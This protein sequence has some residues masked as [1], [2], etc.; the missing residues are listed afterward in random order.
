VIVKIKLSMYALGVQS[1]CVRRVCELCCACVLV[2]CWSLLG[3]RGDPLDG[4]PS[5][6]RVRYA[7]M[8]CGSAEEPAVRSSCSCG[9]CSGYKIDPVLLLW[10]YG[11]R[12]EKTSVSGRAGR[13]LSAFDLCSSSCIVHLLPLALPLSIS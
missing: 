4:R 11:Q 3:S 5:Q 12:I 9:V 6:A 8:Q 1:R 2:V 10:A 13:C 7:G